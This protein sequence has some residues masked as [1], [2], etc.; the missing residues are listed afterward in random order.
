MDSSKEP[1]A[2]TGWRP[3]E[4]GEL[5]RLAHHLLGQRMLRQIVAEHSHFPA[6]FGP[7]G[8]RETLSLFMSGK[9][10]ASGLTSRARRLLVCARSIRRSEYPE[11]TGRR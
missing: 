1:D 10:H 11:Q 4:R 6:K 5:A 2:G 8:W 7:V 9:E 3:C